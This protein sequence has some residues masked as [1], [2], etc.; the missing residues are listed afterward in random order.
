M[1]YGVWYGGTGSNAD[2]EAHIER[3]EDMNAAHA[4]LRSRYDHG[5]A[6]YSTFNYVNQPSQSVLTPCVEADSTEMH[7]YLS[8]DLDPG[9]GQIRLHE[10]GPDVLIRINERGETFVERN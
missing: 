2:P 8:L 5:Y 4:A 6:F 9:T 3:F 1:I 7:I 10:H